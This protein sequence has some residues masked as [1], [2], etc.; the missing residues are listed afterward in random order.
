MKFSILIIIILS[1]LNIYQYRQINSK[2]IEILNKDK[3]ISKKQ[4][5]VIQYR[6]KSEYYQKL[7]YKYSK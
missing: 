7:V 2:N 6:D 1:L 4:D 3:I 5:E